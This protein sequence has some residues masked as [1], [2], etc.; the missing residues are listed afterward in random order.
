MNQNIRAAE[1]AENKM[2][3]ILTELQKAVNTIR[4]VNSPTLNEEALKNFEYL[5]DV[6]PALQ[7]SFDEGENKIISEAYSLYRN[8]DFSAISIASSYLRNDANGNDHQ[9]VKFTFKTPENTVE[10]YITVVEIKDFGEYHVVI[11]DIKKSH[12]VHINGQPVETEQR[13]ALVEM[14]SEAAIEF[15]SC[16]LSFINLPTKEQVQAAKLTLK[17]YDSLINTIN[18]L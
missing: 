7:D 18:A 11:S 14:L 1:F 15:Q 5:E 12:W 9:Q 6:T 17:R 3:L 2:K 8:G 16:N 4:T 13:D 10:A